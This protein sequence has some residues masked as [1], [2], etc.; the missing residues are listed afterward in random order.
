MIWQPRGEADWTPQKAGALW[1]IS[2][3]SL[4]KWFHERKTD[5]RFWENECKVA[6]DIVLIITH[7]YEFERIIVLG[8]A[9]LKMSL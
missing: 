4:I 3:Y 7:I 2:V 5:E 1:T 9:Y 8:Y 6:A